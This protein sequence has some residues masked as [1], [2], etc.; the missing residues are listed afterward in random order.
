MAT[1]PNAQLTKLALGIASV[2]A[3][4]GI[5]GKIA[6]KPPVAAAQDPTAVAAVGSTAT[7]RTQSGATADRTQQYQSPVFSGFDDEDEGEN[8]EHEHEGARSFFGTTTPTRPQSSGTATQ[9]PQQQT[10]RTRSKHS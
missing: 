3:I 8:E 4:A 7:G 1:T 6:A 9:T 10:K 2:A 5:S